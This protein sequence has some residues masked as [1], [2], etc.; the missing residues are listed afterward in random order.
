MKVWI[1]TVLICLAL[2]CGCARNHKA[3]SARPMD[4]NRTRV[5]LASRVHFSTA[6]IRV[7]GRERSVLDHNADL[8]KRHPSA[9]VVLEGHCDERGSDEYNL[10]LGDRRARSVL[11]EL[12]RRG[13][14]AERL[15]ILSKG[16]S[17]PLDSAHSSS[18]WRRNRRVEFIL[19]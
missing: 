15:I 9:V 5:D 19:R 7:I 13:I 6:S 17:E 2:T 11:G 18:A 12:M 4:V 8:L 14:D 3:I 1:A 16:E 10:E